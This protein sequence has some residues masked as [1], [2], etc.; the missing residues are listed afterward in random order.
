MKKDSKNKGNR[1]KTLLL[2]CGL[3]L[4]ACAPAL[5]SRNSAEELSY[6]PVSSELLQELSDSIDSYTARLET[7]R[8]FYSGILNQVSDTASANAPLFPIESVLAFHAGDR[9]RSLG[10]VK[11]FL[12]F[13]DT[14]QSSKE[15]FLAS[16]IEKARIEITAEQFIRT[17]N[18]ANIE[19]GTL[20]ELSDQTGD[21]SN[22][23]RILGVSLL[24]R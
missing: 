20:S 3:A 6:E 2:A 21:W 18:Y 1:K 7:S 19:G 15:G 13:Y 14:T 16:E 11:E 8:D 23:S 9:L 24:I 5:Q 4:S 22:L 10:K 12:Q 17:S